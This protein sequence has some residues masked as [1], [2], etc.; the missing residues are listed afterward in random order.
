VKNSFPKKKFF[1]MTV[2]KTD[3]P[4]GKEWD[5]CCYHQDYLTDHPAHYLDNEA[6]PI[7]LYFSIDNKNLNLDIEPKRQKTGRPPK[8]KTKTLNSGDILLFYT[9][10]LK[11]RPFKAN[12]HYHSSIQGQC[13]YD[14]LGQ[15]SNF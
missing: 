11:H 3:I 9:C 4:V 1:E 5:N 6:S 2:L 10:S 14:W 7:I 8:E 13:S 15:F 12:K